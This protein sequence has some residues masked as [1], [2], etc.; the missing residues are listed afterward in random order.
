MISLVMQLRRCG[1]D[2]ARNL[3]DGAYDASRVLKVASTEEEAG[4][5]R[6]GDGEISPCLPVSPSPFLGSEL[7]R[8]QPCPAFE[9][10]MEGTR[11]GEAQQVGNLTDSHLTFAQ[12]AHRKLASH[13]F[14]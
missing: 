12:V 3:S 6:S 10:A 1:G 9:G 2:R 4:K 13:V 11:F 5:G 14:E 7:L 8:R